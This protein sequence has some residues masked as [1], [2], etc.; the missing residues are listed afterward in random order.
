VEGKSIRGRLVGNGL[1]EFGAQLLENSGVFLKV[2]RGNGERPGRSG[3]AAAD[4]GLRFI[5]KARDRLLLG[6]K[7]GF[8]DFVEDG[9][10]AWLVLPSVLQGDAR[11]YRSKVLV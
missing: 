7:A 3:E 6:G 1:E 10:F 9:R 2:V 8:Y 11:Y 4:D 5:S